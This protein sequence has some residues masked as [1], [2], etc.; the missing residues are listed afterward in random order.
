MRSDEADE[1]IDEC[2]EKQCFLQEVVG[3]TGGPRHATTPRPSQEAQARQQGTTTTASASTASGSSSAGPTR[4]LKK[5]KTDD[6]DEQPFQPRNLLPEADPAIMSHA[7]M[8]NRKK[9]IGQNAPAESTGSAFRDQIAQGQQQGHQ[10][11]HRAEARRQTQELRAQRRQQYRRRVG[12]PQERASL[13]RRQI[14]DAVAAAKL[15]FPTLDID[16]VGVIYTGGRECAPYDV[17]TEKW[18]RKEA[19]HSVGV[20]WDIFSSQADA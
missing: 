3:E 2:T 14:R 20:D 18:N 8:R 11:H 9:N 17:A 10:K 19:W 12:G 1:R 7:E 6:G 5:Q 15:R 4:S 16:G 13:D